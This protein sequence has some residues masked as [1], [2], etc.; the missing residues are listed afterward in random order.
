[1]DI[2]RLTTSLA[3]HI[4]RF[5]CYVDEDKSLRITGRRKPVGT[6]AGSRFLGSS[7]GDVHIKSL[8]DIDLAPDYLKPLV[9]REFDSEA[10]L[11]R[12]VRKVAFLNEV[13][14]QLERAVKDALNELASTKSPGREPE[15]ISK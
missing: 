3:A 14:I 1:M 12:A 15:P 6:V 10:D 4:E 11:V 7:F 13:Q 9:G 2:V 5:D 8:I